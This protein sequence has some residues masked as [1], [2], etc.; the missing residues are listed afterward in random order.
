MPPPTTTN[1]I[2]NKHEKKN[3]II[4]HTVFYVHVIL[5]LKI[6]SLLEGN[7]VYLKCTSKKLNERPSNTYEHYQ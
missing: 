6:N 3:L 2:A 4:I 5:K 1:G 7:G